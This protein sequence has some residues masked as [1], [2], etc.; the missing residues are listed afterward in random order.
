MDQSNG[1]SGAYP[2]ELLARNPIDPDLDIDLLPLQADGLTADGL[3]S[4]NHA[5]G[6]A[7]TQL[8]PD[9]ALTVP[10]P[11]DGGTT[12]TVNIK[13]YDTQSS[14]TRAGTLAKQAIQ[15]DN[16]DLLFASS[17]PETV[18]AVASQ[19]DLDPIPVHRVLAEGARQGPE[20]Q[21]EGAQEQRPLH[22]VGRAG[23]VRQG[24]TG[25]DGERLP[26]GAQAEAAQAQ[27]GL[28]GAAV[29]LEA[30][31]AGEVLGEQLGGVAEGLVEPGAE[32]PGVRDEFAV[33]VF[34]DGQADGRTGAGQGSPPPSCGL[35]QR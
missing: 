19:A 5:P 1:Y 12:Y 15:Q 31:A 3:I 32:A 34:A 16:V 8:V 6:A 28:G 4:Y 33:D 21:S 25:A 9:L 30:V 22:L 35:Q 24:E 26:G 13:S 14:V 7:G 23:L 10:E 20:G 29:V 2:I 17:T 27:A 18:N 11:T